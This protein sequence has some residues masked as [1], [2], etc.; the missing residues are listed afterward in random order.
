MANQPSMPTHGIELRIRLTDLPT[1]LIMQADSFNLHI[2]HQYGGHEADEW[3]PLI[4]LAGTPLA[5]EYRRRLIDE[6]IA[7]MD[8]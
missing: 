6:S 3:I 2:T 1:D 7:E 5:I 8:D 4:P